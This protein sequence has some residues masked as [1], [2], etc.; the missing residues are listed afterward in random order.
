MIQNQSDTCY[1]DDVGDCSMETKKTIH[2]L[3]SIWRL[4]ADQDR[5]DMSKDEMRDFF[6]QCVSHDIPADIVRQSKRKIINLWVAE[7]WREAKERRPSWKEQPWWKQRR[8]CLMKAFGEF[9]QQFYA[10][11][12]ESE[13]KIVPE[14]K[15]KDMYA[16]APII[17]NLQ[18]FAAWKAKRGVV[19]GND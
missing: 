5:V 19:N 7:T 9:Y 2:E 18:D 8:D 3:M 15:P 11:S 10:V 4:S 6:E 17:T 13:S 12:K 16:D 1:D 14:V